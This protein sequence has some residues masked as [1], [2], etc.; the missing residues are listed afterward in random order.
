MGAETVETAAGLL[1]AR[2]LAE[3]SADAAADAMVRSFQDYLV[4]VAMDGVAFE[5][6]FGAENLDGHLSEAYLDG[7]ELV[8]ICLV[9]RR[10]G[11]AR[12]GAFGCTPAYRGRGIGRALM[13][14]AMRHIEAAGARRVTLEV[15]A[16]NVAAVRLY[17]RLGFRRTRALVGYRWERPEPVGGAAV[18]V[19][20][21][22]AR[23]AGRLA[24]DDAAGGWLGRT[25]GEPPWQLAPQTLAAAVPPRHAYALGAAAALLAVGESTAA[26]VAV[27]T[28]AGSR[29]D[30]HA[31]RLLH[32]LRELLPGRR[33]VVPPLVPES[34]G[35]EF[36]GATGWTIDPV[37][38]YEMERELP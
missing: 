8:G 31:K 25:V 1:R 12:I 9:T 11:A 27:H 3:L 21:E 17:E 29:R 22:P 32:G 19:E 15:L 14:R 4:P 24:Q 18:P 28:E 10:G 5:R 7:D 30:G 2:S 23:F 35:R 6:R 38:Q 26:L 36:F 20:I 16:Q 13:E 33:W 34:A 37:G